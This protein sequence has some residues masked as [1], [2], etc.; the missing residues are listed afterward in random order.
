MVN[1]TD[2][3]DN[4]NNTKNK[5]NEYRSEVELEIRTLASRLDTLYTL[6][7]FECDCCGREVGYIDYADGYCEN[8]EG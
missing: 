4:Y 7:I 8:C 2:V 6:D 5:L 1:V 3:L